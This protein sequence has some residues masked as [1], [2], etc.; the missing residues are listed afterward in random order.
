MKDAKFVAMRVYANWSWAYVTALTG[1]TEK[2]WIVP[3]YIKFW[4]TID[5][6]QTHCDILNKRIDH[7]KQT[8]QQNST[9]DER[10]T[11]QCM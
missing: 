7:A 10:R 2:Y 11:P 3:R 9:T 6:C 4:K 1:R 8:K 5:M